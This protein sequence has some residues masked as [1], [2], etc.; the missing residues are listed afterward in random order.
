MSQLGFTFYPKD[1]WT[2]DSFYILSP[3]ERYIYLE[4]L[5]MMYDNEGSIKND[6]ARIERRSGTTIKD[7]VWSKITDLMVK[8]GDQLTHNSVNKRLSRAISSRENGKKGGRPKKNIEKPKKPKL[9]TH[10]N[11]HLE[12]ESEIEKEKEIEIK[13]YNNFSF[14]FIDEEF[15][16]SFIEWLTYKY[17]RRETYKTQKSLELCYRQLKE[18]ADNDPTLAKKIVEESMSNNWAGLFELKVLPKQSTLAEDRKCRW[19]TPNG[20]RT[21]VYSQFLIDQNRYGID[22]VKFIGYAD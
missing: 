8:D 6:K 16:E 4:L 7:D 12:I 10:K 21:S 15:K 11:P 2:S 18:K 5:F 14:S 1:W 9:E 19:N 13:G 17:E 20:D 22:N 3:F